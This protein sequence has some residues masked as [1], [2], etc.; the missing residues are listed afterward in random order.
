[1]SAYSNLGART[2]AL[3]IFLICS[4]LLVSHDGNS[5]TIIIDPD[6][7]IT[8][9]VNSL[10]VSDVDFLNATSPKWL[11]TVGFRTSD[12]STV[13][14]Q[15]TITLAI[16]LSNGES[17]PE[18]LTIRTKEPHFSIP[19]SRS[20]SNLDLGKS[21]PVES[22]RFDLAARKRLETIALPSG[23]I[24]AGVYR[25]TVE[26][27]PVGSGQVTR[28]Y[29]EIVLSNA[30]SIELMFP[31]DG[32]KSV[33]E[34]PLFQWVFDGSNRTGV[35]RGNRARI[36]VYARLPGQSSLE[37]SASGT[38]HLV[39]TVETNY[40]QYPRA[41][42]RPLEAGKTYVWFVEGLLGASGGSDIAVR[43]PIRSF[44]VSPRGIGSLSSLLE[45]LERA[46]GPEY[47]GLFDQIRTSGLSPTGAIRL[48]G[49]SISRT[50]LSRL[51]NTLRAN[52]E[53]VSSANLE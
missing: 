27:S 16:L 49:T 7:P 28:G 45:E 50:D 17:Y 46:L 9:P 8:A 37:E 15:M 6:P 4:V 34:F 24:P 10:S 5:Q 11:F 14:A 22:A 53:S 29:F 20:I 12:G 25:F 19:G 35:L 48:N 52:P 43:S 18:A 3:V 31:F 30:S 32:D 39:E 47:R 33:S 36:H 13:Q 26:V 23:V 1:M 44:T 40:Y 38:P 21:V 51:L 42:V 41:G 2:F